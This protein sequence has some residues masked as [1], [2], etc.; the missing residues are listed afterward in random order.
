MGPEGDACVKVP[1]SEG[2]EDEV[3]DFM[4]EHANDGTWVPYVNDCHNAVADALDAAGLPETP[5]PNGRF[6]RSDAE[7]SSSSA[8]PAGG[9]L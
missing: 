4:E 8:S 6:G 5:S 1:D 7:E 9:E 2:K 3:M